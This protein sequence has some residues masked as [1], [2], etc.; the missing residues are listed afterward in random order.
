MVCDENRRIVGS[1]SGGCVEEDLIEKLKAGEL[2]SKLPQ[3]HRYGE[4]D[5]EAEK[6][7]LPCG[8]HLDIVVEPLFSNRQTIEEFRAIDQLLRR[9]QLVQRRVDL[10]QGKREYEAVTTGFQFEYSRERGLLRHTLGPVHQ[11][12]IIGTSMVSHYLAE[13]AK[14]AE[15]NVIVCD[16][17]VDELNSFDVDS[18]TKIREMPD[19]AIRRHASDKMSAIVALTHDPRIDDMGLLEALETDAFYIGAMGSNRTSANRV[20]RLRQLGVSEESLQ[21]L[22][23]PIGIPIESKTPPE[24]AI[25]VI[26]DVIKARAEL[27][28]DIS[29]PKQILSV[30]HG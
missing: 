3:F 13:F 25:S 29:D 7:G 5:E 23:A 10:K 1:L 14:T 26:A 22:H 27:K 28:D 2:A 24:I 17:R 30:V 6:F 19:D 8:G 20:D 21:R 9:R 11:L 16:P 15:F 4:S 18:I 12:F